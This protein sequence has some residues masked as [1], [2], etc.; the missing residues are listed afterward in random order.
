MSFRIQDKEANAVSVFCSQNCRRSRSAQAI[1]MPLAASL[2]AKCELHTSANIFCTLQMADMQRT[3]GNLSP[4]QM[5]AYQQQAASISPDDIRRARSQMNSMTPDQLKQAAG[6]ASASLSAHEKYQ[7]DGANGLKAAGNQLHSSKQYAAAI[8]KYTKA[9][10][11]LTGKEKQLFIPS[12][13]GRNFYGNGCY[14]CR[15]TL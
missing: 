3:M 8:D 5:Q 4:A 10:S 9:K 7:L 2:F 12:I 13:L 1:Q 14:P 15:S 6:Q 11:N